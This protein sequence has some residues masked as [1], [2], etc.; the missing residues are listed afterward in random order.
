MVRP[1]S[2]FCRERGQ[3]SDGVRPSGIEG[4]AKCARFFLVKNSDLAAQFRQP[5][6]WK[7]FGLIDAK[8]VERYENNWDILR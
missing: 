3:S 1:P 7:A 4:S 2:K 5:S 6:N 8:T